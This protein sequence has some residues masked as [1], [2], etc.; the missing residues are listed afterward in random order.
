MQEAGRQRRDEAGRIILMKI[1]GEKRLKSQ[2]ALAAI[3]DKRLKSQLQG[4]KEKTPLEILPNI[5]TSVPYTPQPTVL[6]TPV[7]EYIEPPKPSRPEK[8]K[9]EVL[10]ED[11]PTKQ[12]KLNDS[13]PKD[14][15]TISTPESLYNSITNYITMDNC[16]RAVSY[17]AWKTVAVGGFV[18]LLV[19]RQA[20]ATRLQQGLPTLMQ[21]TQLPPS[22]PTVQHTIPS[23]APT[24]AQFTTKVDPMMDNLLFG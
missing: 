13:T 21:K 10:P 15:S 22:Q 7:D 24:P 20:L 8:R 11:T 14:T 6:D 16:K 17:C 23:P 2:M 9:A 19:I 4:E 3:Q 18:T 1:A 12:Q 5:L